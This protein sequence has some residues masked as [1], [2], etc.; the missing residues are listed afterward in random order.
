[1]VGTLRVVL[2]VDG[3]GTSTSCVCVCAD[4]KRVVGRGTAGSSN[5][6]SSRL[7]ARGV[8]VDVRSSVSVLGSQLLVYECVSALEDVITP[9]G[10]FILC[11]AALGACARP[12]CTEC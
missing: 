7:I 1:M 10:T 5:Y 2:G 9:V 4:A 6:N 12:P 3:G 11:S 8:Y